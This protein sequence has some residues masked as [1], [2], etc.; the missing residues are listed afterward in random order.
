MPR[1]EL[2]CL[3]NSIKHGGRCVAGLRTDGGGWVRPVGPG[4]GTLYPA[5]YI[6]KD[7]SEPSLMDVI[8]LDVAR[9]EPAAHQPENWLIDGQPWE[10]VRRPASLA[11]RDLLRDALCSGPGLLGGTSDRESF[12]AL[13]K[14]A[15]SA[16]LTVILP[17]RLRWRVTTES[18]KRKTRARFNLAGASYD[19]SV[20][21]PIWRQELTALRDGEH[22]WGSL[23]R[24][25]NRVPILTISLGEPF[26]G[27]CYKLV[28]AVI[29]VRPDTAQ[30]I[31]SR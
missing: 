27:D 16:S 26:E 5:H 4:D 15:A 3:A 24:E 12:A 29:P 10:L 6:L 28:A 31:A 18:S 19:L 1:V 9:H 30:Y 8:A 22:P 2:L 7:L 11:A 17:S 25:A 20:T 21:D 14:A 13:E 23:E